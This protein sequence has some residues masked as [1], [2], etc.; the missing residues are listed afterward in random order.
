MKIL[1]VGGGGREHA[2]A[3]KMLQSPLIDE[4]HCAPGNP[5]IAS[6][7]WCHPDVKTTDLD[8]QVELAAK[9][10]PD[11]VV[12]GPEDPLA[13]GLTERL[14][15]IGLRVFGPSQA[16]AQLE[17][18]K[19]FTKRV[20]GA[21]GAPTAAYGS[22]TNHDEAVA[23]VEQQGAPIVV[24]ADGLAVGKGVYVCQSV[25]EAKAA[26]REIMVDRAFGESGARVVIEEFLVGPE[27]SVLAFADGTTI[28]QM[29]SAQDH[30]PVGEGDTGPNTG[31]M[32]TYA[33]V[34]IYTPEMAEQVQAQVLE[35]VMR[36]MKENG[37]PFVG[38]LFT[39]LILTESGPKVLEFN[40]R[41]GDPETQSVLQLLGTDLV[42]ILNA[43][44]DGRLD[45]VDLAWHNG[46]AC[47]VVVASG[48]YPGPYLKGLPIS[49]L[50][51][52]HAQGATLFHAG[53]DFSEE[54]QLVTAGGRVL[55]VST[56][57]PTLAEALATAY[58]A[59][60]FVRFDGAFYR[61]D[62]GWRAQGKR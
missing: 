31:G 16:A 37:M 4:L 48:G 55:G 30:K 42:Q 17:S 20:L 60:G 3:W 27:V 8:G 44:V 38:C 11:L 10:Q 2:L 36:W 26:L 29:V 49:G 58:R 12:I 24:K 21:V 34:P 35:P 47:N 33:P 32:G 6:I 54:G 56:V 61:K 9:L 18:S 50:D 53:T 45:Q 51:D 39:G 40:V 14:Q 46:H 7:A 28:K 62:I 25:D 5:G 22:F 15:A 19:E 52:A 1:I 57:G 13:L 59:A 41:F 43:C 23:Y